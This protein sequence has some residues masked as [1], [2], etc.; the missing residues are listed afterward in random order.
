MNLTELHVQKVINFTGKTIKLI[1]EKTSVPFEGVYV[2]SLAFL[3][4]IHSNEGKIDCKNKG[5]I[6]GITAHPH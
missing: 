4:V 6:I 3:T 2:L 5:H 1:T